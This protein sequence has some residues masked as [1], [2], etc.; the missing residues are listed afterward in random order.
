MK[1]RKDTN[2]SFSR[3]DISKELMLLDYQISE[4]EYVPN[5]LKQDYSFFNQANMISLAEERSDQSAQQPITHHKKSPK[6]PRMNPYDKE[7]IPE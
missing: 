5:H 4:C 7:Y 2:L 6:A 1:L 3:N